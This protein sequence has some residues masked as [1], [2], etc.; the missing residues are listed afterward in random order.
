MERNCVLS[1]I[2]KPDLWVLQGEKDFRPS[3]ETSGSSAP[4]TTVFSH[5]FLYSHF[6]TVT[7][8]QLRVEEFY[9]AFL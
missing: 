3:K 9:P 1:K 5:P 8:K 2:K 6:F 4:A 7:G